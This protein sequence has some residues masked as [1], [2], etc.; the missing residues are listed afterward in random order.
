[1]TIDTRIAVFLLWG[2]GTV[3]VYSVVLSVRIQRWRRHKYDR[4]SAERAEAS[5]NLIAGFAL[6]LTAFCSGAGV[7]LVLFG[8]AGT[9]LRS[10]AVAIALGAFTGA[11]LIMASE[12]REDANGNHVP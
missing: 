12:D 4:R 10:F 6:W 2:V 11:G 5:R 3:V 9:G 7:A 8:E 1:M